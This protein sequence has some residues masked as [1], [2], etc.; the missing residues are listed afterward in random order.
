MVFNLS[1]TKISFCLLFQFPKNF[2]IPLWIT[3]ILSSSRKDLITPSSRFPRTLSQSIT[4]S[5][6]HQDYDFQ[7]IIVTSIKYVTRYEN[8]SLVQVRSSPN[9]AR[10]KPRSSISIIDFDIFLL[11]FPREKFRVLY[12]VVIP[13]T[14]PRVERNS[15]SIYR[16]WTFINMAGDSRRLGEWGNWIPRARAP[17]ESFAENT[18]TR[19]RKGPPRFKTELEAG[20]WHFESSGRVYAF[21][22]PLL[23][24]PQLARSLARSPARWKT[25]RA[26][27]YRWTGSIHRLV[28][29]F[30]LLATCVAR[31]WTRCLLETSF[32]RGVLR[33]GGIIGHSV[34]RRFFPSTL[35]DVSVANWFMRIGETGCRG[36]YRY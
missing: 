4:S 10:P 20:R 7:R 33:E 32:A 31:D 21:I 19:P 12:P 25:S 36:F 27:I 15:A 1:K 24:V 23:T 18:W 26:K 6:L 28:Y 2:N 9:L 35:G 13:S 11:L 3:I 29:A 34:G 14:P 8:K 16:R 22:A 30:T 5:P 17:L